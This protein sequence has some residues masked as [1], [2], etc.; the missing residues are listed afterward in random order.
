M[1]RQRRSCKRSASDYG[2]GGE[3]HW[4]NTRSVGV[5][6]PEHLSNRRMRVSDDTISWWLAG[7]AE[8]SWHPVDS[9]AGC[10]ERPLRTLWRQPADGGPSRRIPPIRISWL[11]PCRKTVSRRC[12]SIAIAIWFCPIAARRHSRSTRP[13]RTSTWTMLPPFLGRTGKSRLAHCASCR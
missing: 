10:M 4:C 9:C 13:T 3:T 12:S 5:E 2:N 11:L 7:P 1:G 8:G 6:P